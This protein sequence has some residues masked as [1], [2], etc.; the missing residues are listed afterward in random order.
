MTTFRFDFD[1][2]R[3]RYDYEL[4]RKEQLTTQLTLP[5][6]VLGLLGRA[7]VAMLRSF[8]YMDLLLTV[9]FSIFVAGVGT[10]FLVCLVYLGRSYHRQ[11]Y[12]F[13]PLLK[14]TAKSR[15][16]FLGFASVMAGGERSSP[17]L[18][19]RWASVSSMQP[20]GTHRRTMSGAAFCT[21][22]GLHF[23]R[24][25]SLPLLPGSRTWSIR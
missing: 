11:T 10:T 4:Q 6:A 21:V 3:N 24:C 1:Y 5:V 14:D 13:L 15:D 25:C 23:S 22:P 9:P 8:S 19:N 20:T 7:V 17:T 12:V 2:L 16:E 18:T